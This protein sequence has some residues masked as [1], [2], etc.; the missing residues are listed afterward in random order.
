[1]ATTPGDY[2][3]PFLTRPMVVGFLAGAAEERALR[4]RRTPEDAGAIAE[5]DAFA[6]KYGFR[7]YAE[8]CDVSARILLARMILLR[9]RTDEQA[10]RLWSLKIEVAKTALLD[11]DTP[12]DRRRRAT[13]DL[14]EALAGWKAVRT[15]REVRHLPEGDVTLV[16]EYEAPLDRMDE[17]QKA[18]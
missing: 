10:E 1:M 18:R 14:N 7:D 11:P 15:A 17:I 13:A 4:V 5:A 12:E 3:K 9:R 8:F 2:E 16:S 6:R